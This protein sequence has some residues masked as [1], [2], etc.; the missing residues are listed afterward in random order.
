MSINNW[1]WLNYK[2]PS[3][4]MSYT[5]TS[6]N[7]WVKNIFYVNSFRINSQFHIPETLQKL[8]NYCGQIWL[9]SFIYIVLYLIIC[10][11]LTYLHNLS[12]HY[13]YKN[14]FVKKNTHL[15]YQFTGS[16][17]VMFTLFDAVFLHPLRL[18]SIHLCLRGIDCPNSLC[19]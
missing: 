10:W 12:Q 3:L 19:V 5:T 17:R 18:H 8:A 11:K 13:L 16:H 2:I 7:K 14:Q 1:F 9:I 4:L 6:S 15:I